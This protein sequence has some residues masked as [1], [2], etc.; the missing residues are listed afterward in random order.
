MKLR[1]GTEY[2]LSAC[3]SQYLSLQF[4]SWRFKVPTFQTLTRQRTFQKPLCSRLSHIQGEPG[5]S[6]HSNEVTEVATPCL[7]LLI[8]LSVLAL[9]SP[10]IPEWSC[11]LGQH[12]WPTHAS[13]TTN[14][15]CQNKVRPGSSDLHLT[16]TSLGLPLEML[17][18]WALEQDPALLCQL[19]NDSNLPLHARQSVTFFPGL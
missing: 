7:I 9:L 18:P 8:P 13:K 3:L 15:F 12:I 4:L 16:A 10:S 11:P 5:W 2:R 1:K 17:Y 14:V 6:Q 19:L